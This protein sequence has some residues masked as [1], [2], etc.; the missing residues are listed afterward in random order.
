ML[1]IGGRAREAEVAAEIY[2]HT[3]SIILDAES[4]GGYRS[5][6]AAE[7][8]EIEYWELEQ[9]KL[10]RLA[11]PRELD[12]EVAVVTGAASGI[13]R[14]CAAALLGAGAC[15]VGLDVSA[16]TGSEFSEGEYLGLRTDVT[17]RDAVEAALEAAVERF[18]GVDI[19][20]LA[21]GVFGESRPLADLDESTWRLP[22]SVNLDGVAI[23][24][25][26]LYPLLKLAPRKGR[27]VLVGSKNVPAPGTGAAA[28]S[29]SKAAATQLARIAAL[30][31][32]ADGVRVN[33]VHP[34]AVFD[35]GLWTAELLEERARE[36]GLTVEE[37]KRRNLLRAEISSADVARLVVSMCGPA[38]ARTTGAQVPVDGGSDRVI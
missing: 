10:R 25:T 5:L 9:A 31:W 14:A 7:L 38:F 20:V 15:V 28:Y 26:A 11:S 36:Y 30:E 17:D 6:P 12:G 2:T 8:F 13:G 19:A 35:T 22:I 21:A 37:Y 27:V 3:M 1:T 23:G 33:V 32:A 34:D 16:T 29:A 18:G 4:L 24:L